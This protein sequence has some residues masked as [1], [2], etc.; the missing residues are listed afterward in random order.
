M[1]VNTERHVDALHLRP[2]LRVGVDLFGRHDARAHDIAVVIDVVD[3]QVERLDPLTQACF[4][5]LPF[6][7]RNDPRDQIER[8]QPLGAGQITVDCK[9]DPHPAKQDIGLGPLAGDGLVAL[10]SQPT[11]EARVMWPHDFIV[12]THLVIASHVTPRSFC[13]IEGEC[14]AHSVFSNDQANAMP[15]AFRTQSSL[16]AHEQRICPA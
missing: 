13:R 8:D 3:K 4:E 5:A 11:F 6:A 12:M 7:A 10:F 9:G 16:D 15:L 14:A 2:V 1:R